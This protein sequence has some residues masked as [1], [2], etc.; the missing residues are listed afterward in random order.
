MAYKLCVANRFEEYIIYDTYLSF[1]WPA[2]GLY[3]NIQPF[4]QHL[5]SDAVLSPHLL[6]DGIQ[7][8]LTM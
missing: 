4:Q 1:V 5:S 8:F 6:I 2:K 3:S 7:Q